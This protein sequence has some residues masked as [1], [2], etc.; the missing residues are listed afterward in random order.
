MISLKTTIP[1]NASR[2]QNVAETT[3][4][5]EKR[6]NVERQGKHRHKLNTV[7]YARGYLRVFY[8]TLLSWVMFAAP[9]LSFVGHSFTA[10]SFEVC[11]WDANDVLLLCRSG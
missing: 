10:H 5:I 8:F 1:R 11:R 7:S 6:P 2:L 4:T 3:M 9:G